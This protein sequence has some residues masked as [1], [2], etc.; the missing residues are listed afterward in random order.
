[1]ET[2]ALVEQIKQQFISETT[3]GLIFKLTEEEINT[4]FY[5]DQDELPR[6]TFLWQMKAHKMGYKI[7]EAKEKVYKDLIAHTTKFMTDHIYP[8]WSEWEFKRFWQFAL[9]EHGEVK[10]TLDSVLQFLDTDSIKKDD[11]VITNVEIMNYAKI[12]IINSKFITEMQFSPKGL[13]SRQKQLIKRDIKSVVANEKE[14]NVYFHGI[15]AAFKIGRPTYKEVVE[16][17]DLLVN[18]RA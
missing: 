3:G 13:K 10:K 16:L 9:Q 2:L 4:Y 5:F 17:Q 12:Y 1:M 7:P 15:S 6:H 18:F 8:Y 11:I 14:V